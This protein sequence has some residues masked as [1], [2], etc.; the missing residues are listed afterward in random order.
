MAIF[1]VRRAYVDSSR[2]FVNE[3][4]ILF[5]SIVLGSRR[6]SLPTKSASSSSREKGNFIT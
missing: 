1:E 4:S 3:L 6:I 5:G 2:E